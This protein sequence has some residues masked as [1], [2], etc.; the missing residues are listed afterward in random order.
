TDDER[1]G[2]AGAHIDAYQGHGPHRRALRVYGTD[3]IKLPRGILH[4]KPPPSSNRW[5]KARSKTKRC[6]IDS[7]IGPAVV[8]G[9]GS[10]QMTLPLARRGR[11]STVAFA[12]TNVHGS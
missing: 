11:C 5:R 9:T 7:D 2:S 8:S 3:S 12:L 6:L 1:A 10:R 4:S